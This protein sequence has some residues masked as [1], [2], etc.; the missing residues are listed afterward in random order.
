VSAIAVRDGDQWRTASGRATL[1]VDG[2]L[3][4]IRAGDRLRVFAQSSLIETA[5]NPGEFDRARYARGD[6][7]L[8]ALQTSYPDAVVRLS[9]GSAADPRRWLDAVRAKGYSLLAASLEGP[10]QGLAAAILLGQREQVPSRK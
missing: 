3:L 6:R 10:R 5:Q 2:H 1:L 8:F 7:E 4:G 9:T